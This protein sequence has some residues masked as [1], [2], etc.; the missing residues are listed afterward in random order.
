MKLH[1]FIL[2]IIACAFAFGSCDDDKME[3]GSPEGQSDVSLSEIPL[4]L[5][6]KIANYDYIKSYVAKHAPHMTVGVG[7]GADL[8]VS[9]PTYKKVAD[10]NYQILTTGNAMKHS[11]VVNGRGDLDFSTIDAFFDAL[12][13]DMQIYGHNFIWHTQQRASYLNNLI[14]PEVIIEPD[15]GGNILP[16]DD[17]KN[18]SFGNW[19]PQNKGAGITIENNEGMNGSKAIKM[20]AGSSTNAWDLQLISPEIP[21]LTD[22]EYE[23]TF[24]VRSEDQGKGRISFQNLSS[25]YPWMDW[26]GTGS[27]TEAFEF[28]TTWTQVSVK[29]PALSEGNTFFKCQFDFGYIPNATYYIDINTLSIVDLSAP[30]ETNYCE[31]GSFENGNTGWT[32]NNESGGIEIVELSDAVD[33]SKVLK[34]VANESAANAWDLQV[35]SDDMPTLPDNKV[36]VSFFVKADQDGK[37]RISFNGGVSNKWPWMNWTGYQSSWTEAFEVG[38]SWQEINFVLQDFSVNFVDGEASWSMN[39]DFGYMPNVTYYLDNFKV[40]TVEDEPVAT[41]APQRAIIY[42]EKTAEEKKELITNAMEEWIKGMLDHCKDRVK[43]WDVINEP[44]SDDCRLRG[45]DFVPS[46]DAIGDDEFYWGQYMG[47]EYAFKAFE[48][49]R[50]YGN[51]NDI[52][53]VNDYNLETNPNKLASLIGLVNYIEQNGQKV[54]GI[55]T[56]MHVSTSITREQVDA[57]FKTMAQTGKL[58]RVTELDVRLGTASPATNQLAEQSDTYQMIFE[59]YLENVPKEQQSGIT[60]WSLTDHKREHEYWL[61]DESPNLFDASYGR[62]HAYKGVCD[63]IA[64]YDVSIDF[65]GSL[66]NVDK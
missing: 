14:A 60:I 28:A 57:M 15:A 22:H 8:Y 12:P 38:T 40:T 48:F 19:N 18:G 36:R 6:E 35:S 26:L 37:G 45:V 63:G 10:D 58:V 20:I 30:T 1:K 56:Q 27:Y 52:L 31:N 7:L 23:L 42:V 44:I 66:W 51:P 54:D 59:S 9:D 50:K 64:G 16:I 17:L 62:K 39:L 4:S 24:W 29:L 53:F 34:M 61:P 25:N 43:S 49:A 21:A 47:K 55:G 2:P 11:S 41:R 46:A 3:W 33:G 13:L 32:F 5:I 65:D